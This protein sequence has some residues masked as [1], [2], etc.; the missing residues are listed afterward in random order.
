MA[1]MHQDLVTEYIRLSGIE[2]IISTFP[3]QLDLMNPQRLL[4]SKTPEK[5]KK[6]NEKEKQRF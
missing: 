5:S 3:D 1:G 4:T 2:E 6:L